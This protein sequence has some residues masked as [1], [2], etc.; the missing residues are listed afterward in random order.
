MSK[1]SNQ[2]LKLLY[3]QKILLEKT[4]EDHEIT[5]AEIIHALSQYGIAAERKSIYDD[6]EALRHYGMDI[7]RNKTKVTGY[8]VASRPFELAEL[9]L[10]V[11]AVQCSRFITRKKSGELIRKIENLTSVHQAK[12]LHRQVYVTERVKAMNESIY[13]NVDR[14]HLAIAENRQISFL[15]FEY[16]LNKEKVNRKSGE[17]YRVSPN[18]LLWDDENYY[19]VAYNEKYHDFTNY[20][21]DRMTD[22]E[23]EDES[24]VNLPED[25]SFDAAAYAKKVF[26]MFGGEE[27]TV[28]LRFDEDLVNTVIDRYGKEVVLQ[29]CGNGQFTIR[30]KVVVSA[31]FFA[32]LAMFGDKVRI[33]SPQK[34]VDR[35]V[36]TIGKILS[37]YEI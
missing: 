16:N 27:T 13:Y 28:T 33:L 26:N 36:D 18:G 35:Y 17:R 4:D 20:R 24:S 6:L 8:A 19:L 1:S 37:Q 21:V 2:K 23:V 12:S 7:I 34:M 5:V 15:Y 9:K 31:T 14:I 22:L 30:V 11:D 3:L 10:L 25:V 32:W 29:K